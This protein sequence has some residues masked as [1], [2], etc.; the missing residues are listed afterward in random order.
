MI[1]FVGTR[2][3]QKDAI[4][5]AA[6]LAKGYHVFERWVPGSLTNSSH[7]LAHCEKRV[8]NAFDEELPQF[9]KH[10]RER[11]PLRPDLVVCLNTVEN[12]ALLNECASNTVPTIGLVDTDANPASVTYQIPGN[13]DSL[14][15]AALVA[16]VL[17]RAGEEGQ[18][19]RLAWAKQGRFTYTPVE[20]EDLLKN[21]YSGEIE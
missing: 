11:R 21:P 20:A 6:E 16:G 14:R 2:R 15:S 19:R 1:V 7:I 4:V 5:R 8:V 13:D 3:G 10:L 18:K 12:S 9:A 17:G